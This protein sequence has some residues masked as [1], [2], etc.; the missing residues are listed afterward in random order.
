MSG[1]C[2]GD[3]QVL[4]LTCRAGSPPRHSQHLQ[5]T[6]GVQKAYDAARCSR[7]TA[8]ACLPGSARWVAHPRWSQNLQCAMGFK[9]SQHRRQMLES[10]ACMRWHPSYW[11]LCRVG[12]HTLTISAFA[13]E[14]KASNGWKRADM[15][16]FWTSA[17]TGVRFPARTCKVHVATHLTHTY[18]P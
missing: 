12:G 4:C 1:T 5:W 15:S 13:A 17:V 10:N 3:T 6:T 2:I 18:E 9:G 11:G 14:Q 7:A 16:R 8:N